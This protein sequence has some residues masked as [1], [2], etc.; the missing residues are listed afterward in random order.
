MKTILVDAI[1]AFV[2][3]SKS[4]FKEMYD[5]LEVFPNQKIILTGANN[6]QMEKFG[7]NNMPYPVFT[8][9]HNPEKSDPE[10]YKTM[11][12]KFNLT[13]DDVVYF[14]HAKEAVDSAVLVGIKTYFY[15]SGKQDLESLKEF[16]TES[17]K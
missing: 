2:I 1:H 7:L 15:D 10:Y 16:L 4:I 9:K 3:D 17:L 14:E 11:L 6:E 8:L 13:A 12:K 5:L